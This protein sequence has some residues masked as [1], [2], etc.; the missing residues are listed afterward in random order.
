MTLTIGVL[1]VLVTVIG[2]TAQRMAGLGFAL[3]VSPL[4]TLLLGAHSGVL[5]VNLLGVV[6]SVLILPR[7]WRHIDW[8]MFRWLASF[9]VVGA[10]IGAWVAQRTSADVMAVAVG[11]IVLIALGGS[12]AL[13]G[14]RLTTQPRGPRAVAGFSSGMMNALAGVGGPAISAY[15]VLTKWPQTTFAATLQPYFA[16]TG[17]ASAAAKLALDPAGLPSTGWWFW[18]LVFAAVVGGIALGE[19]LLRLVTP[20][21]VRRFV[22]I[23]AC[24]G[25]AASLVTGLVGLL[26]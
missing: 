3:L 22:I 14:S 5:L 24:V 4:M 16:L 7:V 25:A 15:A 21:Q 19:R 9:A 17:S 11:A 10:V 1:I 18:V 8:S 26:N 6:S 20:T 12:L 13:S 2:A 23:L